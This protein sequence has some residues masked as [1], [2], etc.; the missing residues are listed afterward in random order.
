MSNTPEAASLGCHNPCPPTAIMSSLYG[1]LAKQNPLNDEN[2][3]VKNI[4]VFLL[5]LIIIIILCRILS[6]GLKFIKQPPVVGE[7]IAGILLGPTVCIFLL[8]SPILS[9]SLSPGLW[10]NTRF[11]P[12]NI[13]RRTQG[14]VVLVGSFILHFPLITPSSPHQQRRSRP[15]PLSRRP[16]D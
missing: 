16:R 5:Q 4:T 12:D 8:Q 13:Q 10:C 14:F 2:N 3:P 9:R 6:F 7:I 15:F 11:H 1:I